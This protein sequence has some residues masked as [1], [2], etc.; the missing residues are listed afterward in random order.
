MS[1]FP[2]DSTNVNSD[3]AHSSFGTEKETTSTMTLGYDEFIRQVEE[4][5]KDAGGYPEEEF[6]VL[7]GKILKLAQRKRGSILL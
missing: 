3:H 4:K 6:R 2:I 1:N 5:L 7:D